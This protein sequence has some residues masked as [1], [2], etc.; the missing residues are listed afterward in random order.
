MKVAIKVKDVIRELE[1]L[2]QGAHR[3]DGDGAVNISSDDRQDGVIASN[4]A[5]IESVEDDFA[6]LDFAAGP[7]NDHEVC[8][9]HS[10]THRSLEDNH[11][12]FED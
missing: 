6:E 8:H 2:E 3:M 12:A 10:C 7:M 1:D 9:S 4:E 5:D 11:F